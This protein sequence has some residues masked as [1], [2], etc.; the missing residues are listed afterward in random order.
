MTECAVFHYQAA[1]VHVA[2][3]LNENLFQHTEGF[4]KAVLLEINDDQVSFAITQRF[5]GSPQVPRSRTA[6]ATTSLLNRLQ[7][8]RGI[9]DRCVTVSLCIF[10]IP[11]RQKC[12]RQ[13]ILT[14]SY[15]PLVS[16][17]DI[18]SRR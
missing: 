5:L 13:V 16:Y 12:R 11:N 17:N 18:T 14:S 1:E 9:C 7:S 2:P 8:A 3:V 15:S 10:V 6:A 4:D